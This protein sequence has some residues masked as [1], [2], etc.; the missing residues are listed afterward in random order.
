MTNYPRLLTGLLL[1]TLVALCG[2]LVQQCSVQQCSVQHCRA[3]HPQ[4]VTI[5]MQPILTH[6]IQQQVMRHTTRAEKQQ[7]TVRFAHRIN[8]ALQAMAR[9]QHWVILPKQ[10][11]IAGRRDVTATLKKALEA[12]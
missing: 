11:V 3:Q 1:G 6:F 8:T 10:A 5:D 4:I 12:P 9:T 2:C 7:A